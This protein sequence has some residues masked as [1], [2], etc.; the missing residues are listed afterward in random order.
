MTLFSYLTIIRRIIRT[1][2]LRLLALSCRIRRTLISDRSLVLLTRL[3]GDLV[4]TWERDGRVIVLRVTRTTLR[5]I[6]VRKQRRHVLSR[7]SRVLIIIWAPFTLILSSSDRSLTLIA[8][9]LFLVTLRARMDLRVASTRVIL[10]CRVLISVSG[11]VVL[12][13][14]TPILRVRR[15]G[16]RPYL[17]RLH[18]Y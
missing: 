9:S 17:L 6:W 15:S 2:L 5:R 16:I 8:S 12:D 14:R 1:I 18:S 11:R 7:Y 3:I 4:L 10:L 13:T